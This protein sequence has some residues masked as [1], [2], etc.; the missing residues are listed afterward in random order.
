MFCNMFS[1]FGMQWVLSD[2]RTIFLNV[3]FFFG[4]TELRGLSPPVN[5]TGRATAACRRR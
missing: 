2:V 1:L 3:F 4:L 5:Y